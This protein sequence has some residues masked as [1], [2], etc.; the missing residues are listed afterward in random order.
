MPYE[1]VAQLGTMNSNQCDGTVRSP[2]V[3]C[4]PYYSHPFQLNNYA[5][6]GVTAQAGKSTYGESFNS[7]GGGI[8]ATEWTSDHI[9]VWF[10]PRNATPWD[11]HRGTPE[12][13]SWPK[14][15]AI[16]K[17]SLSCNIDTHFANQSLIF[18]T[19]FCG[20]FAGGVWGNEGGVCSQ[21]GT[22]S[23][24]EFVAENPGVFK[25]A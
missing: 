8:Y 19:T 22:L 1:G 23:C 25:D 2:L 3:P 15:Q 9:K 24:E 21:G 7:Q 5:G 11:I 6:C 20:D 12:P 16:F 18:D 13:S 14:P 4:N 10:F 17:G